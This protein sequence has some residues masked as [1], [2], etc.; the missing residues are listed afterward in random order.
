MVLY[1]R[2]ATDNPIAQQEEKQ[3]TLQHGLTRVRQRLLEITEKEDTLTMEKGQ[4]ALDF[5]VR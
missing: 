3:A 5:A 2:T 1:D 4:V